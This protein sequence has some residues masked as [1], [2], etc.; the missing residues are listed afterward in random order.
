MKTPIE[1]NE[2]KTTWQQIADQNKW[3]DPLLL[4]DLSPEKTPGNP[5]SR[6]HI[7]NLVTGQ[8]PDP[9]LKQEIFFIGRYP[10]IRRAA[11]VAWLDSKTQK[12][13]G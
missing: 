10:A 5:Y 3:P 13:R 7:R 4:K 11:W 2:A 6:G 9:V 8:N 1:P 12:T